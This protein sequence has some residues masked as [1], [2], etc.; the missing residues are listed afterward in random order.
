MEEATNMRLDDIVNIISTEQR[1]TTEASE[2]KKAD[3]SSDEINDLRAKEELRKVKLQ[4]DI[5]AESL[6]KQKQDRGE[7]KD[8]ASMIFNFMCWY[9]FAVFFI[10]VLN[11]ITTT[12]FSVNE[13][14]ILAL[15]GTTA[16]EVIGTFRFV[17]KYLFEYKG[18]G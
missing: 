3:F 11:G 6:E 7:R 17:A 12:N 16:I 5:L 18:K 15:L 9:L 1:E 2:E 8:Y 4:N 10:I 13:N 14:V